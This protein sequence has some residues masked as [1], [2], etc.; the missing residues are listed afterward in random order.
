MKTLFIR[1][2]IDKHSFVL[3]SEV[4]EGCEWVLLGEGISTRKYDGTCCLIKNGEIYKR[5]DYKE[6]RVLPI[7]AIPCQKKPDE[8]TGHFPHWVKCSGY[9]PS[10]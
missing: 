3:T 6:G 4:T 9:N 1:N 5:F 8:I 2:Y 7:N 10:D